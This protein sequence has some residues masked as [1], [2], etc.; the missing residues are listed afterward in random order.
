MEN[1]H[2]S[3]RRMLI[4]YHLSFSVSE[5][6]YP[7]DVYISEEVPVD[8]AATAQPEAA[9]VPSAV[10]PQVDRARK[11]FPIQKPESPTIEQQEI[12]TKPVRNRFLLLVFMKFLLF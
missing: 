6:S 9:V 5:V 7:G 2:H 10:V 3:V 4:N 11:P 12:T 8:S 1:F